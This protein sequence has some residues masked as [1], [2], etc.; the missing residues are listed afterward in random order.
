MAQ[1]PSAT[2]ANKPRQGQVSRY[3]DPKILDR[4]DRLELGARLIVEGF[5]AGA[6]RS[7]Y[8]GFSVEFAKHREYVFGDDPRHMDWKL[9]G[10]VG[11]YYIK[12]YE[13]ETNFVA[14]ILH[15]ASESMSYGSARALLNKQEYANFVTASLAHLILSQTDAVSVGV[16][17][18]EVTEYLEPKQSRLHVHD[19]CR[20]L[21][22]VEPAEKTDVGR[23]MNE[24]AARISR[25]GLVIVVSDLLD[26]PAHIARG[27]DH[28]SHRRHEVLVLHVM[29]PCELEFPFDGL[30]KFEGLEG[31]EEVLCQPRMLRKGYLEA[32]REHV[33]AIRTACE[34]NRVDYMLVNTAQPVEVVLQRFLQSRALTRARGR[35]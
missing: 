35:R 1:P 8:Q 6:H 34:R 19:V 23:I 22:K 30:I 20:V 28:L 9:Y 32:L 11:K 29:D 33:L 7:P 3:L 24:F 25:R 15:D 31:Y 21:E 5:M 12:Q 27:L 26:D 18:R 2:S 4:L 13:V 17:N 10:R 16:F 14:H